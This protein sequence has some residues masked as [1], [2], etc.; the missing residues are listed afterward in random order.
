MIQTAL[1]QHLPNNQPGAS[2]QKNVNIAKLVWVRAGT[3]LPGWTITEL[4]PGRF[5]FCPGLLQLLDV[6]TRL[7]GGFENNGLVRDDGFY[8]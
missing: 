8:R 4:S 1:A 5:E 7:A 3:D 2:T 6:K